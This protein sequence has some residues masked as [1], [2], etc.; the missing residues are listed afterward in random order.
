MRYSKIVACIL[1]VELMER[2]DF[3]INF[4]TPGNVTQI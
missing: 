3:G 1:E 2:M 4:L